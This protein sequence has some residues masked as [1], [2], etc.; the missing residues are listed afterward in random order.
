M[1]NGS[2]VEGVFALLTGYRVSP[3]A[4]A[5][6]KFDEVSHGFGCIFF[7]EAAHDPAFAGFK[8][9]IGAGLVSHDDPF[10]PAR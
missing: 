1:E 5:L 6:G 2:V 7:K 10:T 3:L 9:G 4:L 8:N